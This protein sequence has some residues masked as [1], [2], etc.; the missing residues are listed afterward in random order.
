MNQKGSYDGKYKEV[1]K[2]SLSSKETV[3]S[4]ANVFYPYTTGNDQSD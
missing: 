2:I 4:I 1:C 3:K